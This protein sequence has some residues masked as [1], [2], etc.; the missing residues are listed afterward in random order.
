MSWWRTGV[1]YE[2][3][4]RSFKDGNGDGVGD[5]PGLL[6]KLDYFAWLGIEGIWITPFFKSPMKDHGYD[7]ADYC[8]VDEIFGSLED[9]KLLMETAR[10]KGIKV[11]IDFVPNH[12]SDQHPWFVEA[13]S[14]KDSAKRDWFIW[15]DPKSDGSPPSNWQ[16]RFGGGPAWTFDEKTQ[17][18]YMHSFIPEQP[19]LNWRNQQVEAAMCDVMRFWFG[20]GID[21]L[22]V[23]VCDRLIKDAQFRDNPANAEWKEGDDPARKFTQRYSKNLPENHRINKLFRRVVDEYQDKCLIGESYLPI[24]EL[25]KYYG[26]QDEYHL[27]F[28]FDLVLGDLSV[29]SIRTALEKCYTALPNWAQPGWVLSNHDRPRAASRAGTHRARASMML[30]ITLRGTPTLYYGDELGLEDVPIPEEKAV[31]PWGKLTPWRGR[32]KVRTPMP[33]TVAKNG[34]FCAATIEPWLPLNPNLAECS[35]AAQSEDPNSMLHLTRRLI[36]FRKSTPAIHSGAIHLLAGAETEIAYRRSLG[37]DSYVIQLNLGDQEMPLR[38]GKVI[39]STS[40]PCK[41]TSLLPGGGVIIK[42]N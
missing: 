37:S 13:R 26:D 38:N 16:S 33:W 10:E 30:L 32:D 2:V 8:A 19:D 42:E 6:E 17:Q 28:N 5:L 36:N 23:D 40:E 18:Y 12:S 7:V 31:D 39:L 27:P 22:R 1:L 24:D 41:S 11:I 34:G 35:V 4:I 15:A 21:G 14:S 25:A 9:F 29:T 3:Y 20:L